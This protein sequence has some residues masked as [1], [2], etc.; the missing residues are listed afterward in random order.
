[1]K[2]TL[3]A[4][5]F[6]SIT[7]GAYAN[8]PTINGGD[9]TNEVYTT[10]GASI[11]LGGRAEFRGDFIGTDSGDEIDGTMADSSRARINIGGVS[12]ISD[13]LSAF[14]FYE[15]E[16]ST[17]EGADLKQRY[18]YAGLM[19]RLGAMSFGKQ[20]TANVQ[21]SD[22]SDIG[23]YTGDQKAFIDAG[24]EQQT[25]NISYIG[26]FDSLRVQASY[27]AGEEEDSNGYGL[28]AIYRLPMGLDLGLGYTGADQ[29]QSQITAGASYASGG[30][31]AGLT[32]TTGDT[33]KDTVGDAVDFE[34]Y[35][36]AAQYVFDNNFRVIGAYQNQQIDGDDTA[37]FFEL[38]GGYDFNQHVYAYLAYK[39]NQLDDNNNF[40]VPSS[41]D[42]DSM[43][44]GLKYTF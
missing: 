14:G 5:A 40:F 21:L 42:E 43:R 36:L 33:V 17:G 4:L 18:A 37:D 15:A 13:S 1:M 7:T 8:S 25:N 35:E 19:G 24:D 32:Y 23:T 16:Q 3:I 30:F 20:N 10:D 31:Y 39:F 34:G 11:F 9:S 44:L 28:S 41:N 6:A 2:K 27:I 12:N 22:M 29:D 38:T 26:E